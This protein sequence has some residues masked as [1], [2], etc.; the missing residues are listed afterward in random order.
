[1]GY[2]AEGLF[3]SVPC[4]KKRFTYPAACSPGL[5]PRLGK[6]GLPV[7]QGRVLHMAVSHAQLA[8]RIASPACPQAP[9]IFARWAGLQMQSCF[10]D[11]KASGAISSAKARIR[12]LQKLCSH[13]LGRIQQESVGQMGVTFGRDGVAVAEQPSCHHQRFAAHHGVRGVGVA[14]IV[15]A[16][17][18][19]QIGFGADAT[20]NV[21]DAPARFGSITGAREDK[22]GSPLSLPASSL[23]QALRRLAEQHRARPGLAVGEFEAIVANLIPSQLIDLA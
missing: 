21:G 9:P 8:T 11:R 14:E 7:D 6:R 12:K 5:R 2:V 1:M 18:I 23:E 22:G 3:P 20:P 16:D 10:H 19:G 4:L 15:Q 13:V 17:V